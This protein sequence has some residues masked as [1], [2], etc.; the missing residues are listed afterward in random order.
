MVIFLHGDSYT[1]CIMAAVFFF[2]S[3]STVMAVLSVWWQLYFLFNDGCTFCMVTAV[4]SVEWWLYFLYGDSCTFCLVMAVLS[5]WWQLY[6]LLRDGCT[7]CMVTAVLSVE[8]WLYFLYGDSCT[9]CLV[10]AVLSLLSANN[11]SGNTLNF[12]LFSLMA[13]L[14]STYSALWPL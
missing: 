6:F 1:F 5:V 8:W 13:T 7:F 9:F 10:M 14:S 2:F 4:L 11:C 12:S 3:C